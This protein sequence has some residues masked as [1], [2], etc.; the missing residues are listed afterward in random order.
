MTRTDKV[1]FVVLRSL[2]NF[3]LLMSLYGV[4][5]TFGPALLQETRLRVEKSKGVEYVVKAE[6]EVTQEE[7]EKVVETPPGALASL[8]SNEQER[9]LIPRDTLFSILIPKIGATA[10]VFPNIDPGNEAEF[11]NVLTQGI[12]HAKGTVFPGIPGN[13]Y[14]FA[15]STDN[16]WNVGRYNAV[17]YLL[18]DVEVGD[19]II[20]FFEG[21]RH[22]YVVSEKY[23]ADPTE[24][25]LLVNSR[26][27]EEKLI[28]QTCWP[29]G[30]TWRRLFVVARPK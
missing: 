30:T 5:A 26:G 8:F 24:V 9:I 2:G 10:K 20:V 25:S 3:L 19:D 16:W 23:V 15:H 27:N 7:E 13:T 12:A 17:F 28:L 4:V 14:L 11:R 29:P 21:R 18:K 6:A 1:K 22:N